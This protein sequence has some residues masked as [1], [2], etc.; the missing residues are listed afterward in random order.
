MGSYR[1]FS[2]IASFCGSAAKP[3]FGGNFDIIAFAAE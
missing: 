1:H 3:P 2:G